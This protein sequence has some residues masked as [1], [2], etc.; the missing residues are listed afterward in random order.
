[1]PQARFLR[2]DFFVGARH[3]LAHCEKHWVPDDAQ[4]LPLAPPAPSALAF[5]P[6]KLSSRAQSRDLHI[7]SFEI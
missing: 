3:K 4:R 5:A 6:R 2:P 1:V 7:A